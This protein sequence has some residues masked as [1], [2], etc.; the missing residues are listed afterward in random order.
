MENT[1]NDHDDNDD[2][3]TRLFRQLSTGLWHNSNQASNDNHSIYSSDAEEDNKDESTP[4]DEIQLRT[5]ETRTNCQSTLFERT[6]K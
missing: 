6:L 5:I 2:V 3:I 4:S 1:I